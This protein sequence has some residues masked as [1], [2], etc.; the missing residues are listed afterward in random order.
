VPVPVPALD[1]DCGM[2][3][4][5]AVVRVGRHTSS[6]LTIGAST[7][8]ACDG[9]GGCCCRRRVDGML[10][11]NCGAR[12]STATIG[13]DVARFNVTAADGDCVA[14]GKPES[15]VGSGDCTLLAREV[16]GVIGDSDCGDS[17]WPCSDDADEDRCDVDA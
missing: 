5:G 10:D 3:E 12:S 16:G 14:D 1:C 13:T 17:S 4:D 11:V 7:C 9:C 2:V 15:S 6:M 8:C